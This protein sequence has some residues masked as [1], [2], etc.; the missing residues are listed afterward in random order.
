VGG[1]VARAHAVTD[2]GWTA[3]LAIPWSSLRY[4]ADG[5]AWGLNF[6]RIARRANETRAWA[7]WPAR[8]HRLPR[9]RTSAPSRASPPP[10]RAPASVRAPPLRARPADGARGPAHTGDPHGQP[11]GR[12]RPSPSARSGAGRWAAR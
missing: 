12:R 4:R 1:G 9:A 8:L 11:R 7:P 2:S 10:P 5:R 3:E 6:Y